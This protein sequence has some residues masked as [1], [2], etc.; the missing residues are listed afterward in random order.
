MIAYCRSVFR[1]RFFW[2]SLAA[3]DIRKRYLWSVLGVAWAIVQPLTLALVI[4]VVF[5]RAFQ[6]G[7]N[8]YFLH[9]LSGLCFWSFVTYVIGV[10]CVSISSAETYILQHRAPLAIY[11]MRCALVGGFHFLMAMLPVFVLAAARGLPCVEAAVVFPLAV[12]LMFVFGWSMATVCGI[13]NI[14]LRDTHHACQV[15]LTVLFYA[16]PIVWRSE[17]VRTRRLGWVVDYNPLAAFVDLVRAPLVEGVVP[18]P[19]VILVVLATVATVFLLAVW[20]LA[21]CERKIVFSL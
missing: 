10:G 18:P 1:S 21:T 14:Y 9:V 19:D 3:H 4:S 15:L 11:P 8:G 2:L 6:V 7:S 20:L 17:M 16:T 13:A 5:T 12:V